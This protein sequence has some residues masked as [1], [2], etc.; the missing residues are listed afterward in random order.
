MKRILLS[1]ALFLLSI[2]C[3]CQETNGF[4][5]DRS[6]LFARKDS[7]SLFLDFYRPA[8]GSVTEIGGKTKPTVLFMF[9]GGFLCGERNEES[10]KKWFRELSLQ[11]YPVVS[12]DYRLGLKGKKYKGIS[13]RMIKDNDRAIGMAVEDL[14]SA[15]NYLI[16]HSEELG[17][18]P[19]NIV[20]SGSS[21]G[22]I[23]VLTGEWDICNG[24]ERAKVLPEGF[25]YAGAMAFSGAIFSTKG[26]VR[27][28]KCEPC[29][30]LFFHG[31]ADK[32]V[33]YKQIALFNLRFSGAG[34]II[35]QFIKY[36]FNYR[37]FRYE[38]CGHE[39]ATFMEK[40]LKEEIDFMETNVMAG[41][42]TTIDALVTDPTVKPLEGLKNRNDLYN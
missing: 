40:C 42:R 24:H 26:A 32:V 10:Y 29:P 17:I 6:L 39:V 34:V 8:E 25:N 35:R 5:P 28:R 21:A 7:S 36:G 20:I 16:G 30:T 11:G 2:L 12:I 9:G 22:A 27:Y 33:N 38:G 1:S 14:F 3:L 13:I 37:I 15:T 23:A 4:N 31:T 19:D 18:D 41:T